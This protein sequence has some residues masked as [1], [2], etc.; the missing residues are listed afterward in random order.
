MN[1]STPRQALLELL[2][3]HGC[4]DGAVVLGSGCPP[5]LVPRLGPDDGRAP[6]DLAVIAPTETEQGQRGWLPAAVETCSARLTADGVVY[7][8]VGPRARPAARRLLRAQRL[9]VE[10]VM[11]HLADVAETRHMVPLEPAAARH[12]FKRIVPLVPWKRAVAGALLRLGGA[13]VLSATQEGM[14][15]V[16]RR[17]G[18]RPLFHWLSVLE[19]T[20]GPYRGV[21]LSAS[22]RPAGPRV[23][24]HPFAAS[25][26]RAVVAKVALDEA[27][28]TVPEGSR[29]QRLAAAARWA[30]ADV[31]EL[32]RT[33]D[34]CGASVLLETRLDGQI[35][36]PLLSRRP[37]RLDPVLA[38]VSSWLLQ[39]QRLTATAGPLPRE[40]LEREVLD[41][42]RRLAPQ[43]PRGAEYAAALSARCD[44]V[45]GTTAPLTASHND[46][47]MWNVLSDD[48]GRLGVVDWEAAEEAT[49]PLKDFFYACVDAVAATGRYA[50]RPAAYDSCFTSRGGSGGLVAGLEASMTAALNVPPEVVEVSRHACWLGHALNEARSSAQRSAPRPFLEIVRRVA[51]EIC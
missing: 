13:G 24:L 15:L 39:W 48:R 36:A 35:V 40:V 51:G 34:V 16:A 3:P 45:E 32:L 22:W 5:R 47:T 41:P 50:D 42:A 17:P 7:L 25:P 2:L 19:D 46:L 31:P 4:A 6:V 43:L 14:G 27:P 8:L 49:L 30:G 28:G 29:L 26:R 11:L 37:A 21:V 12:A 38:R 10:T 23:V 20:H 44:A 33:G 9:S 1:E 18:A